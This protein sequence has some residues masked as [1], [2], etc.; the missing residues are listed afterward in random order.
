MPQNELGGN[1]MNTLIKEMSKSQLAFPVRRTTLPQ[2]DI[3]IMVSKVN[4][5]KI[6]GQY[7]STDSK[8]SKPPKSD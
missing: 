5:A 7:F 4:K 6:S 2:C 8:K 3:D 1:I